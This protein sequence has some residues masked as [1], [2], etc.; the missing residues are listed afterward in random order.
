MRYLMFVPNSI[1]KAIDLF[2]G[3]TGIYDRGSYA[4]G[5]LDG[6]KAGG[7]SGNHQPDL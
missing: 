4:Q 3:L 6:Y 7:N 2:I 5:Y 1:A